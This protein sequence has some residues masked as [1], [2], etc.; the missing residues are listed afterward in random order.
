MQVS[1]D[2]V[3]IEVCL[4]LGSHQR[5]GMVKYRRILGKNVFLK[6]KNTVCDQH[7]KVKDQN[8]HIIRGRDHK[9]YLQRCKYG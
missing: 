5:S 4:A 3:T 7:S 8:G 1:L 9:E 6:I 2:S